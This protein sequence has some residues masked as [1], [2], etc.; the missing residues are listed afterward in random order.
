MLIPASSLAEAQKDPRFRSQVVAEDAR[1]KVVSVSG[2]FPYFGILDN[3]CAAGKV[4]VTAELLS[5]FDGAP[6][7]SRVVLRIENAK[8][9]PARKGASLAFSGLR[10]AGKGNDGTFV[11]CS[12][13]TASP[14]K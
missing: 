5:A 12:R 7:G 11:Y 10:R 3:G 8:L 4:F 1:V 2:G 13:G 14:I 6:A 9:G